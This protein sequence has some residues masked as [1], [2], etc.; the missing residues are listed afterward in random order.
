MSMDLAEMR[1]R[2]RDRLTE[3]EIE[4]ERLRELE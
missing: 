2:E 1:E 4:K 3:R